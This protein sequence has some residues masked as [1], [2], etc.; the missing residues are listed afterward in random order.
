M[1]PKQVV[2]DFLANRIDFRTFM[3][4]CDNNP[5]ILDWVQSVVP[6]SIKWRKL[7]ENEDVKKQFEE[8]RNGV[9]SATPDEMSALIRQHYYSV[10]IPYDIRAVIQELKQ[11][12]VIG[13]WLNVHSEL[14]RLMRAAFPDE[15]IEE[16][17]HV[18]RVFDFIISVCPEYIGGSEIDE[19]N[20]LE[21]IYNE[22]PNG[23]QTAR[24][25]VYK[26]RLKELFH[27]QGSKYPHWFQNPE[28]PM[29]KN[30]PMRFVSQ[31]HKGDLFNY[32]FEDVDTGEQRIVVQFS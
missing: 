11:G 3:K 21:N 22:L 29:G 28:W 15:T 30:S 25:K 16:S 20:I 32:V 23:S 6:S 8:I 9:R 10:E 7:V 18:K 4:E 13:H 24:K 5:G 2:Y 26:E 17:D 27:V 14:S 1:E 12:D 19:Q 31:S